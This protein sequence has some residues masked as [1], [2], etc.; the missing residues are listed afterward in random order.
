MHQES[1]GP[2]GFG[3][4]YRTAR[5]MRKRVL[6]EQTVRF[7]PQFARCGARCPHR[8]ARGLERALRKHSRGRR[9]EDSPPCQPLVTGAGRGVVFGGMNQGRAKREGSGRPKWRVKC[10]AL[11]LTLFAFCSFATDQVRDIV[12]FRG[13]RS[14]TLERPLNDFLRRLPTVPRFDVSST[15]NYKGYTATWELK[16]SRLFLKSF[17]ATTNGHPFSVAW[18]FPTRSLPILADWYSGTLHIVDGSNR[19]VALNITNG[20]VNATNEMRMRESTR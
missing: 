10:M 15:A 17:N 4:K 1:R 18:L 9:A 19:L 14:T 12:T 6:G 3:I 11:L 5:R 20:L 2:E 8:A 16:D 13:E 7:P